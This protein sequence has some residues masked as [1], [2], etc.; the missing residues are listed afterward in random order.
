MELE[1]HEFLE[2]VRQQA[3]RQQLHLEE[4]RVE[5]DRRQAVQIARHQRLDGRL[6]RW[7]HHRPHC[8]VR[9]AGCVARWSLGRAAHDFSETCSS[10]SVSARAM[11]WKMDREINSTIQKCMNEGN[12][13][14][15]ETDL[16]VWSNGVVSKLA[17]RLAVDDD[18]ARDNYI[19]Y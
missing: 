12:V 4:R 14:D 8:L 16:I 18:L 6:H 1:R 15:P 13:V 9:R 2:G 19:Q 17:G 11:L 3:L 5:Q 7:L 10:R